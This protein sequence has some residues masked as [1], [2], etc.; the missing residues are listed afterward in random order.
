MEK[1]LSDAAMAGDLAS[2]RRLLQEDPL[3]LHRSA[4]SCISDTPLHIASLLGH[5]NF[6]QEL[7]SL[8]PESASDLDSRGCSAL[9]LAAA[10][11]HL[12]IVRDLVKANPE[13]CVLRNQD[14]WTPLHLA[15]IKGRVEVVKELIRVKP[16]SVWVMTDRSETVLHLCVERNRSA[17]I[18]SLVDAIGFGGGEA[19]LL[20]WKDSEG[21][22]VLHFA[23]SRKQIE[24]VKFLVGISGLDLNS[25]NKNHSTAL[26]VLM[27]CPRDLRDMEIGSILQGAGAMRAKDLHIITQ[28]HIS[29][30]KITK[31]DSERK[32]KPVTNHHKHNDWLGRKRSALMVVASLIATVAFQAAI[33]PPGGVWQDDITQDAAPHTAGTSIMANKKHFQYGQFMIFNTIAFLA[34][35]SIILLLISGL[36]IKKRRWMWIQMVIMWVA[37]TAQVITYF[38]ALEYMSPANTRGMLHDVVQI[39][40]L[41]WLCL[42][43]VVFVGNVV[44]MNLWILRKYGLV[45]EKEEKLLE[46]ADA[47]M[48]QE[49]DV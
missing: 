21:N 2:L 8:N 39:S 23:V 35:L 13:M 14:G 28:E 6:V 37:I 36:P 29:I 26:D 44:R 25:L 43:G 20:N 10:K 3:I 38:L 11:G 4:V 16:D 30:P 19:E 17:M 42:M 48:D 15:A 47:N 41:S 46:N 12:E 9:H 33:T 7:L 1:R 49:E 45:K 32:R 22:S 18:K 34:S 24:I 5:L 31:F 40:V 27:Q